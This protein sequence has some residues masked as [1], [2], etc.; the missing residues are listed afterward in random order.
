MLEARGPT[1]RPLLNLSFPFPRSN[2][3]PLKFFRDG[4]HQREHQKQVGK[5]QMI[6]TNAAICVVA[7]SRPPLT[8]IFVPS[9]ALAYWKLEKELRLAKDKL[10]VKAEECASLSQYKDQLTAGACAGNDF[11]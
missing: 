6:S 11:A 7:S 9:Q 1:L 10:M 3:D 2:S 4:E 8:L 5:M